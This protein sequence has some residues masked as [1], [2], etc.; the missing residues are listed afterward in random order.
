MEQT[1]FLRQSGCAVD[2]NQT[3]GRKICLMLRLSTVTKVSSTFK[4]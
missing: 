2:L 4:M 3:V 1:G